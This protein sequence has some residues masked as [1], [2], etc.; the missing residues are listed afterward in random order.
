MDWLLLASR[1]GQSGLGPRRLDFERDV[2]D[3]NGS[4]TRPERGVM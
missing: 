2:I 1:G 3:E 4:H